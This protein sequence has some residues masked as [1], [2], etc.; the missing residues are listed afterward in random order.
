[1]AKRKVKVLKN[2]KNL[3]YWTWIEKNNLIEQQCK[4][5]ISQLLKYKEINEKEIQD[6]RRLNGIRYKAA[7]PKGGTQHLIWK[8]KQQEKALRWKN[9]LRGLTEEERIEYDDL[10]YVEVIA[11]G[12]AMKPIKYGN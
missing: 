10:N 6:K 3:R 11:E 9:I 12:Y 4:M 1:M 7:K 2:Y 5:E 8:E